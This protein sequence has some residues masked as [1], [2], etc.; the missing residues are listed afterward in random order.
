MPGAA[1]PRSGLGEWRCVSAPAVGSEIAPP[2]DLFSVNGTLETSLNYYTSVDDDGRTLFC[3]VTTDGKL[4]PTL[5]VNPGDRIKIH[6]TNMVPSAPLGRSEKVSNDRHDRHLGQHAF[7]RAERHARLPWRRSHPH[8]RQFRR[9]VR[10]RVQGAGR[11]AAGALLVSPARP[12]HLVDLGAGGG[13]GII[14]VQGIANIQPAR[15]GFAGALHRPARRAQYG[16]PCS[17]SRTSSR[18]RTGMSRSTM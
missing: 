7:P 9:D 1:G 10:L 6:L 2:P 5:H 11:R 14:E 16:Q 12:R 18:C 13:T 4:S 15:L 3:F 17:T 8:A